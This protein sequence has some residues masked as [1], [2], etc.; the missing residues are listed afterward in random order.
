MV[1]LIVFLV[2][3][4]IVGAAALYI[5]REKKRGAVC[6]GCPHAAACARARQKGAACCSANQAE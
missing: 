1:N 4:A 5:C 2:I 3:A 6:V